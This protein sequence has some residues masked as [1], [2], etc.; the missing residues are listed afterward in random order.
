M[1]LRDTV[2]EVEVERGNAQLLSEYQAADLTPKATDSS[3]TKD[4]PS[5][6]RA[7]EA[8]QSASPAP[9]AVK[10]GAKY[11]NA[12]LPGTVV[13]I[14]VQEGQNVAKGDIVAVIES[15]KMENEIASP[16]NGKVV[17]VLAPKGTQVQTGAP[18]VEL[19]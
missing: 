10:A 15:M 6:A 17:G 1:R 13:K 19:A 16:E 7:A 5:A 4:A 9:V 14:S 11:V 12:P 18:L 3:E 8:V 2:Y